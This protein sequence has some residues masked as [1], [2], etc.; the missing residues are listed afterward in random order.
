MN[1]P[2]Y[3]KNIQEA[4][5]K[6]H[7]VQS[8]HIETAHVHETFES[9]TVWNGDVEVFSVEH[10]QASKCYAWAYEEDGK[11]EFIAV[12]GLPPVDTP[13]KAVQ[14]YIVGQFKKKS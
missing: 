5:L 7:G 3:F 9:K 14:A 12:L 4:I 2:E 8:S 6:T 10:K 1:K 11:T 13:Q